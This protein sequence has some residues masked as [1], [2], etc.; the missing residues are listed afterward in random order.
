MRLQRRSCVDPPGTLCGAGKGERRRNY[1]CSRLP[2]KQHSYRHNPATISSIFSPRDDVHTES[3]VHKEHLSQ[4]PMLG[5]S[6]STTENTEQLGPV[7]KQIHAQAGR[8]EVYNQEEAFC[9]ANSSM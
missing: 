2:R 6:S 8:N 1:I 3:E 5:H 4:T 7:I 9:A